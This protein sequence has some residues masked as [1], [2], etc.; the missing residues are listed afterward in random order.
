MT[1]NQIKKGKLMRN[2]VTSNIPNRK[3]RKRNKHTLVITFEGIGRLS[4][5]MDSSMAK[6]KR[7]TRKDG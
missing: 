5:A 4:N 1:R 2:I 6:E 7:E 3:F